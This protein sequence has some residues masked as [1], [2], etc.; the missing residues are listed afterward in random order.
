MLS[1]DK[2]ISIFGLIDDL[3]IGIGHQQ[4]K[5]KMRK[6]IDTKH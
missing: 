6:R 2:I 5:L 3:F 1:P 4:E